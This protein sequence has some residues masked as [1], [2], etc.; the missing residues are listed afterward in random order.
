MNPPRYRV[1]SWDCCVSGFERLRT[2][3]EFILVAYPDNRAGWRVIMGEL[4]RDIESCDRGDSFDYA[5]AHE[6]VKA[7][8]RN[9][10]RPLMRGRT[11]SRALGADFARFDGAAGEPCVFFLYVE[12]SQA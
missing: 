2:Q 5:A 10:F 1:S 8:A 3:R 12:D 11:L 7:W 9:E 6:C 4:Q